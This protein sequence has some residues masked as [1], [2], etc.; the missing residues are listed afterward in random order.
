M[1]R[2]TEPPTTFAINVLY[3]HYICVDNP[4]CTLAS[5]LEQSCLDLCLED[6]KVEHVYQEGR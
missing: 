1:V 5:F 3:N 2:S 6:G 4:F